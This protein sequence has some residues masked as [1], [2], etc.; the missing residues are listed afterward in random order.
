LVPRIALQPPLSVALVLLAGPALA[1]GEGER[2]LLN[3]DKAYA[4]LDIKDAAAGYEKALSQGELSSDQLQRAYVGLGSTAAILGNKDKASW[5]FK[6]ALAID[7]DWRLPPNAPP[8]L[9]ERFQEAKDFWAVRESVGLRVRVPPE[10]TAGTQLEVGAEVVGDDL[11]MVR[12]LRLRWRSG[13]E[14]GEEIASAAGEWVFKLDGPELAGPEVQIEIDALDQGRSLVLEGGPRTVRLAPRREVR[15]PP[16]V[17]APSLPPPEPIAE[18]P[19]PE[20][21][22]RTAEREGFASRLHLYGALFSVPDL[23][24]FRS[25]Y[26]RWGPEGGVTYTL[27]SQLDVGAGVSGNGSGG[28]RFPVG[29]Q[30]LGLY[31]PLT[32]TF[33]PGLGLFLQPRIGFT[34]VDGGIAVGGG[35]WGGTTFELWRGRL[36]AGLAPEA[37]W[38]R[39]E[40]FRSMSLLALLGYELD[41]GRMISAQ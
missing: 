16:S 35:V 39:S 28:G 4:N 6:R 31:R 10:V 27:M 32:G 22:S 5:A 8:K 41:I 15:P 20:L 13:V 1:A 38:I 34:P 11:G 40:R 24:R 19:E 3:A 9:R 36:M 33:G 2:S 26:S 29:F 7:P 25:G 14:R 30:I 17:V 12:W 23:F 21:P 37:Y 18:G